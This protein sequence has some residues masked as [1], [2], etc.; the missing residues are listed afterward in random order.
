MALL[1]RLMRRRNAAPSPDAA[2]PAAAAAP[3]P[4]PAPAGAVG[5]AGARSMRGPGVAIERKT[6][7]CCCGAAGAAPVGALP[8]APVSKS[9]PAPPPMVRM[10]LQVR[11]CRRPAS[12]RLL[13]L[14]PKALMRTGP[15]QARLDQSLVQLQLQLPL[16]LSLLLLLLLLS[17]QLR[18]RLR[19]LLLI[20]AQ[21]PSQRH[22]RNQD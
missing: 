14:L 17:L 5:W 18:L 15:K 7:E 6:L 3:A 2:D 1:K 4:P 21:W 19:L 13:V 8:L 12:V 11:A 10:S 20:L 22:F 16:L 9:I